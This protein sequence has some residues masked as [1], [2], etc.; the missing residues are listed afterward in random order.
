[1]LKYN[2]RKA[3]VN[4]REQHGLYKTLDDLKKIRIID[5]AAINKFAPYVEF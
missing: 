4:Y 3:L 5:E 2:Q 1:V